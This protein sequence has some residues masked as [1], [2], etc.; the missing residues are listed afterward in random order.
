MAPEV[1]LKLAFLILTLGVFFAVLKLPK[2][3]ASTKNRTKNRANLQSNRH[4]VHGSHLLARARSTANREQ[5]L[6]HAKNALAEADKAISLSPRDS[7]PH[8][9][10]ALALDLMDRKNAA[11]RSLDVALSVPCVKSLSE[12]ERGDAL[13]KRAEL[14]VAVNRRRR[15]DSAVEDLVEAASRTESNST[16]L[17][18]LG[19]CYEWKGIR[20]AAREA[21]EKALRV[22]PSSLVAREGLDRL[23]SQGP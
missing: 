7:V 18:L 22:E 9:L 13:V 8:I 10:K 6:A 11:L 21:F 19:Q 2:R 4:F 14:K 20:D 15:I 17:C 1:A 16:A 3:A 12:K 5:S 23:A